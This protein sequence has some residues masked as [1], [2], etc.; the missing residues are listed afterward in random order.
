MFSSAFQANAFQQNAFQI[1]GTGRPRGWDDA[2]PRIVVL[3]EEEEKP[4]PKKKARKPKRKPRP[5]YQPEPAFA[6]I[7]FA[8]FAPVQ[9]IQ[10]INRIDY[11]PFALAAIMQQQ[12]EAQAAMEEEAIEMLLLESI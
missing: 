1:V 11:S 7:E 10:S 8:P 4:E 12:A 5:I 6:P 2:G 3:Y 9:P